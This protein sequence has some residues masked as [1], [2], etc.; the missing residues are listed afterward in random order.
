MAEML[1]R[2]QVAELR[3]LSSAA[4]ARAELHCHRWTVF[5]VRPSP[6]HSGIEIAKCTSRWMAERLA[7]AINALPAL[8]DAAEIASGRTMR[9]AAAVEREE[10]AAMVDAAEA[11]WRRRRQE[12]VDSRDEAYW[13]G[14]TNAALDLAAR[15]RARKEQ[16]DG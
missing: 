10:I 15:I 5:G 1:T 8:L 7:A 4:P 9:D 12:S 14:H 11:G 6:G 2:E 3:N 13:W 16:A